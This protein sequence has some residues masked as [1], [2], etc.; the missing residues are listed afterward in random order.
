MLVACS[1]ASASRFRLEQ[2]IASARALAALGVEV[3]EAAQDQRKKQTDLAFPRDAPGMIE[4][5]L[6]FIQMPA[7]ELHGAAAIFGGHRIVGAVIGLRELAHLPAGM[8]GFVELAEPG[9]DQ[10]LH[11]VAEHEQVRPRRA[12]R[13]VIGPI[14]EA[15]DHVRD[16]PV[17]LPVPAGEELRLAETIEGEIEPGRAVE[18]AGSATASSPATMPS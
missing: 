14:A 13:R 8:L 18:P 2:D 10:R 6:G 17:A 12:R 16:E 9:G 5:G 1:S 15:R 7:K 4:R 11:H 3:S